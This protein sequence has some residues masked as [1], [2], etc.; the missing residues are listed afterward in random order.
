MIKV[1]LTYLKQ[2]LFSALS[3]IHKYLF[4][5]IY[6]FA[7]KVREGNIAKGGFRFAPV[8]Y[9]DSAL[10]SVS[11]MPQNTFDKIIEK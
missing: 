9:L 1:Y 7:G 8:M 4:E 10:E 3:F 11:K 2:V 6:D 5:D